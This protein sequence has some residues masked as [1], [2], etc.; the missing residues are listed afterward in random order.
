MNNIK[1]TVTGTEPCPRCNGA[2]GEMVTCPKC[3]G[4]GEITKSQDITLAEFRAL[5][6]AVEEEE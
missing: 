1:I 3:D 5:M 2:G 6:N 4:D